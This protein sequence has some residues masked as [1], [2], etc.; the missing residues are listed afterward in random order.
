MQTSAPGNRLLR[1]QPPLN[2]ARRGF[3]LIEL[4]VVITIIALSAALVSLALRDGD[5]SR[6]EH[7]GQRLT[8]LLETARAESRATGLAV[9]WIPQAEGVQ[10]P[11]KAF[12]FVGLPAAR[13]LPQDWLDPRV[14]AQVVGATSVSLGPEALIGAQ[15]VVLRLE[16]Q[17]LEIA[18][19]GLGPFAVVSS[20]D[21]PP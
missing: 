11:G 2:L 14:N 8:M 7:E 18:T 20:P 13:V 17:R 15:R 19:D 21:T 3:T 10:G 16:S 4:L 12:R 6:L 9:L 5:A 1:C